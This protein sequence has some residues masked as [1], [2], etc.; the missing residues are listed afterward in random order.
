[1]IDGKVVHV[2]ISFVL[3]VVENFEDEISLR[4]VDCNS[5]YWK[6]RLILTFSPLGVGVD[7]LLGMSVGF[8]FGTVA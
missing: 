1:M 3:P 2:R 6:V 5:P 7:F 8:D 4:G